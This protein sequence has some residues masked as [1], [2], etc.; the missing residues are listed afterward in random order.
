MKFTNDD[1]LNLHKAY[2]SG[3]STVDIGKRIG[4]HS[5]TLR[6]RFHALGLTV[7]DSSNAH[8]ASAARQTKEQRSAWTK[9]AHD[10]VRGSKRSFNDLCK[11]ANGVEKNPPPMSKHELHFTELLKENLGMWRK[12]QFQKAVGIYNLDFV[13]DDSIAVEIFGG[14]FHGYDR[15]LARHQD[16]VRYILNAGFHVLILWVI[17][18][19]DYFWTVA[20]QQLHSLREF[21]CCHPTAPRQYR[22]VWRDGKFIHSC[23][24]QSDN[25]PI[26]PAFKRLRDANGRY[27]TISD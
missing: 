2:M 5:S 23:D 22:V 3:E 24:A 9:A 12:V 7:R 21:S 17:K 16:R 13:V 26:K 27:Y 20:I 14:G 25:F 6:N 19:T 18:P 4:C 1:I 11:R 8:I 15:H 10:A